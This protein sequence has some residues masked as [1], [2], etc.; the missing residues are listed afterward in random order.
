[1][2]QRRKMSGSRTAPS[3][4]IAG[5]IRG[6]L[7][8]LAVG[9]AL[10][11]TVEFRPRGS[12]APLTDIVG[13]GPFGLK[14]GEW[15]DDTSMALCLAESIVETQSF[16]PADQLA[17]Y[18]RW[19]KDGHLSS[20]GI[21]FDIGRQTHAA[22]MQFQA[23]GLAACGFADEEYS[24]NGSLM[25]LSPVVMAFYR[26]PAVAIDLA[27]KS[28]RTTHGSPLCVDACRY[29]A[30]L[31]L[32][33][34]AGIGKSRLL[35][36]EFTP[37]PGLWSQAPL[38][39]QIAAIARG[40]WKNK[41]ESAIRTSGFVVHTL[42]AALWAFANTESYEQA[43]L[44]AANLGDDAD[45]TGAVC[46]QLAGAF[47]GVGGIPQRWLAI[48]ANRSTVEMLAEKLIAFT[49]SRGSPGADA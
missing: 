3:G 47:Y 24:G 1:M 43:V 35:A 8:G 26:Q 6:S 29:F 5:R 21:C 34:F 15:T 36:P 4:A 25:R 23:T 48:L 12:F 32:G 17:R 9:D 18:V 20:N 11:T 49:H 28:S 44:Q 33:A 22:L 14:P 46:G 45:T 39:P 2:A 27:G 30:A 7:V 16:N 10:G 38:H 41:P 13:G 37:V 42:E 40:S 19:Y 31:L